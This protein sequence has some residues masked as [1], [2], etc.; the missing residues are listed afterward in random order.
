MNHQVC[1]L[2]LLPT[3]ANSAVCVLFSN[4]MMIDWMEYMHTWGGFLF[5][6]Q[7]VY[8][9]LIFESRQTDPKH[10]QILSTH[11]NLFLPAQSNS[12]LPNLAALHRSP[13]IFSWTLNTPASHSHVVLPVVIQL[14]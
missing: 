4:G 6:N 7:L 13:L 14:L 11:P 5:V 1:L 8:K 2:S 9:I 12:K 10:A 3:L